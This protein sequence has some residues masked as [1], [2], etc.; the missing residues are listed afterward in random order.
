MNSKIFYVKLEGSDI[1]KLNPLQGSS[2]FLAS[3]L[4]NST[5][6]V[7]EALRAAL[8][9]KLDEKTKENLELVFKGEKLPSFCS[10]VVFKK[11]FDPEEHKERLE[12]LLRSIAKDD[13]I[14][15]VSSYRNEG[16]M[17]SYYGKKVIFD[18]PSV[19]KDDRIANLE[20]QV[21]AQDF[22][23]ER[24]ELY[25]SNFLVMQYSVRQGSK[26]SE[27]TYENTAGV[28]LV[29]LMK[30]SPS[31]FKNYD[32]DRYIHRFNTCVSDSGI[33]HKTLSTTIYVQMDKCFEQF[34][35][36]QDAENNF[37]LQLF[38]SML[39][40]SNSSRVRTFAQFNNLLQEVYDEVNVFS[41]SKE[42][43]AMLL[44]EQF[45]EADLAAV[46]SY[47][48]K[49]GREDEKVKLAKNFIR[50]GTSLDEIHRATGIDI[51]TLEKFKREVQSELY[52]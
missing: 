4:L 31:V 5:G 42:V 34:Q 46:K 24:A 32:T 44:T 22:I 7:Q 36:N 25:S 16:T 11:L 38:L 17:R 8:M 26:K 14:E 6:D 37:E 45:M 23:F 50:I 33:S 12:W 21:S 41:K 43:Q 52:P 19:L 49:K 35:N 20:M 10:D 1:L 28:L 48:H 9:Q 3:I 13:S 2:E 27:R 30:N 40:D 15:V 47:E 51:S 29:V 18:V 39:Y